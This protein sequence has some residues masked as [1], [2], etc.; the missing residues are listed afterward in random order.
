M[1]DFT[2]H[3][4][5]LIIIVTNMLFSIGLGL[6]LSR[7]HDSAEDYFLAG[8]SMIWP[9]IGISLFASNI[10][11]T[12]LIGLSGEAYSLYVAAENPRRTQILAKGPFMAGN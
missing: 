10:S 3:N 12:T 11:S 2:L 5:D 1:P 6:Y 9:F 8:R 7:K 4:V